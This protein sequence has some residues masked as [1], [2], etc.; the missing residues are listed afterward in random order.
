ML[1]TTRAPWD[2]VKFRD[3]KKLQ[4]E[5][6]DSRKWKWKEVPFP[7]PPHPISCYLYRADLDTGLIT[8]AAWIETDGIKPSV[9]RLRLADIHRPSDLSLGSLLQKRVKPVCGQPTFSGDLEINVETPT[10]LNKLQYRSFT[11]FLYQWRYCIDDHI[12]WHCHSRLFNALAIALLRLAAWDLEIKHEPPGFDFP[13]SQTKLPVHYMSLPGWEI[14]ETQIFWFHGYLIVLCGAL[15]T[16]SLVTAAVLQAKAFLNDHDRMQNKVR[17]ILISLRY[18]QFVELLP[19]VVKSSQLLPLIV[20]TSVDTCSPGFRALTHDL[21]SFCWKES[22]AHR[23]Q[24]GI[25]LLLRYLT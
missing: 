1:G 21:T 8:I 16:E 23:E 24:W 22:L 7:N 15:G 19:D 17:L 3:I 11:D 5:T 6:G 25:N 9:F 10:P 14:S 18:V 13:N 4:E 2:E 20:N 12:L